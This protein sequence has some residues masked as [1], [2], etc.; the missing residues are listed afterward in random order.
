MA[1]QSLLTEREK[2]NLPDTEKLYT[3][4]QSKSPTS[5]GMMHGR[6]HHEFSQPRT[7]DHGFQVS[8]DAK[9][10]TLVKRALDILANSLQTN[11]FRTDI[12]SRNDPRPDS[13][14]GKF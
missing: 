12:Q 1:V 2:Q 11:T 14:H 5:H 4:L 7:S 6:E 10:T 13:H 8:G 3:F 9:R